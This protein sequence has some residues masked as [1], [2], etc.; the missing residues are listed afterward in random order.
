MDDVEKI[1]RNKKVNKREVFLMNMD[2]NKNAEIILK[3]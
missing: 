1:L 2:K 3:E